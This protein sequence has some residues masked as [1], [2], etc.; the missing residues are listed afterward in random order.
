[1]ITT[2]AQLQHHVCT[3]FGDSIQNQGQSDWTLPTV[4]IGQGNG[5]GPQIWA[6]VSS[7]LFEIMR[8]DGFVATFIYAISKEHRAM[9]GFA[10]VDDTDLIVSDK[11]NLAA[12]MTTKMQQS[13]SLW[14]QLLQATGGDLVPEKCFWYLIDFK[15]SNSAWVYKTTK[16][17]TGH[18]HIM[19]NSG[20]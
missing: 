13:L 10:F 15:W 5:A 17:E 9:A 14:H 19:S 8:T 1:M 2:L 20:K 11:L 4:G 3:A 16:E 6:A 7:P 12:H 18:L